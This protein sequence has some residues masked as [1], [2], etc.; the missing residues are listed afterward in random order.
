MCCFCTFK[1]EAQSFD[2]L[3]VFVNVL[4]FCEGG[5]R[6]WPLLG[7]PGPPG[8]LL[9]PGPVWILTYIGPSGPGFLGLFEGVCV[10]YRH[11]G[12]RRGEPRVGSGPDVAF[13][14]DPLDPVDPLQSS[15]TLILKHPSRSFGT[16]GRNMRTYFNPRLETQLKKFRPLTGNVQIL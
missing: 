12:P 15:G 13:P 10:N 2:G 3:R 5:R 14:L 6:S 7:R 9:A 16:F 4:H 1:S 11:P 8:P